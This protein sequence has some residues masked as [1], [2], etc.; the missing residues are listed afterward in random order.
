MLLQLGGRGG[1]LSPEVAMRLAPVLRGRTLELFREPD[2]STFVPNESLGIK[3]AYRQFA[4]MQGGACP[5]RA[6]LGR[7]PPDAA[8]SATSQ[9]PARKRP[10]TVP[11]PF[12][13]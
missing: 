3:P 10:L 9:V 11:S 12:P 6:A 1:M 4:F 2:R 8:F 13:G 7:V 5:G